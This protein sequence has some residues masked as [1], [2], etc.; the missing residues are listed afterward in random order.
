LSLGGDYMP[1]RTLSRWVGL[2]L[3]LYLALGLDLCVVPAQAQTG[4]S[5][6]GVVTDPSGAVVAGAGVALI[7]AKTQN[8]R[9]TATNEAG[10]YVFPDVDPG[11]YQ[12][13]VTHTGFAIAKVRE[14]VNVGMVSTVNV[15]LLVG[16]ATQE[17]TVEA[18]GVELQTTNATV[19]TTMNFDLA[20]ALPGLSRDVSGLAMLQPA[21]TPVSSSSGVAGSVAGSNADQNKYVLDGGNNSS[22]MDGNNTV[23]LAGFAGNPITGFGSAIP[24]GVVPTPVETIEEFKVGVAGQGGDFNSASGNQVNMVTRRGGDSWHG[25]AYEYYYGTN[26]SANSWENGHTPSKNRSFTPLPSRHENRFGA[27]AGGTILPKLLGGKTYLFGFYQGQ[28]FPNVTT[29]EKPVPSDLMR[30]GVIQIP[31]GSN[32]IPFNLNP[33]PVTVDGVTYAPAT[34][35]GPAGNQPCDP[36]AIGLNPIVSQLWSFMPSGNDVGCGGPFPLANTAILTTAGYTVCDQH[37]TI[38]YKGTI[39]LPV[40][41]NNWVVR[42]DHDFGKNWH[43]MSSYRYYRLI[44]GADT[45][46][47]D[48]GGIVGG[49][50]GQLTALRTYPSYP[51]Y[52]VAGLTTTITTHLTNDFRYNYTY[53]WWKWNGPGARIQPISGLGGAVEIGGED[54]NALIPY[55]VNT[56]QTR[57]RFWDGQDH[58]FRDDLNFLHGNHILQFGGLYQR[59]FNWHDRNDNGQGIS[60]ANVYQVSST[61]GGISWGSYV[62]GTVPQSQISNYQNLAAE[63]LGLVEQPQT[64]YTR[65]GADLHLLP[66]GTHAQD[67]SVIDFYSAYFADTWHFKPTVTLTYGLSYNLEMPPVEQQARQVMLVDQSDN[68]IV[69]GDYFAQRQ[70]AALAGKIYDPVLGFATVGNVGRGRKYPYDPFYGGFG[71]R[72][73]AAWNPRFD[74]GGVL[75]K[76]FGN[77][78][79]VIRGGYSRIYGRLN[80]V[81]LVLVPLLGTGLMQAVSCVGAVAAQFSSGGNQCLGVGGATPATA[82]RIGTDGLVAPL[83]SSPS[84]TLPQPYFPG[85]GGNLAAAPG[86]GLDPQTRPSSNDSFTFSLQREVSSKVFVEAGYIGKLIHNEFQEIN[87]DAVPWMLTLNGQTFANA[88]ANVYTAICG[89]TAQTCPSTNV[90]TPAVQPWFEQ[91]LGG[92]GSVFCAGQ[93][94][95][96]AA[97]IAKERN[98]IGSNSVY[99]L[100]AAMAQSSSWTPGLTNPGMNPPGGCPQVITPTT[101]CKQ[102]TAFEF[103]ASNGWGNYNAAYVSANL[104]DWHGI[105]ARSN[106]TWGRAFG[107]GSEV[108]ARSTRTV[109]NPYDLH[110]SYGTQQFDVKFIYN[111]AM[112]YKLPFYQTQSGILGRVLGGWS[113]A[114]VFTAQSGFPLRVTQTE[115]R[116]TVQAFGQS[117]PSQNS[118]YNA[119]LIN[120]KF[121]GGN[122]L[123]SFNSSPGA[124]GGSPTVNDRGYQQWFN[125]FANPAGAYG[126][127]RRLILGVDTNGG[128]FGILRGFPRWNLDMTFAKD[129]R[130]TERVGITFTALMTNFLNHFQPSDPAVNLNSP[131]TFG[132]VTASEYDARQVEFGL[133]VRF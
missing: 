122:S 62:P 52:F 7:D 26:F 74:G 34:V 60:A 84:N 32:W 99:Q 9:T 57:T 45:S 1:L 47:V 89:L 55:N 16:A 126:Q 59:N 28:R 22:D 39:A 115:S 114:P 33:T 8:A 29:L 123:H 91:A 103:D 43:F 27:S 94:S 129:I 130:T 70:K 132:R 48:M 121:S 97:V 73:S 80:G 85:L 56:Q 112:N 65:N 120:G 5:V 51:A 101:V 31:S 10:R 17:V 118:I 25:S 124:V 66:L 75:T 116:S 119:V 13:I 30:A 67:K 53:N 76:L 90:S 19:G 3:T 100:W 81:N 78:S 46:Q 95:C 14:T 133:R 4:G 128:G 93:P 88:Y 41:D 117:D 24:N 21:T 86:A 64:L 35:C 82:F 63:V 38:G 106:F 36:R 42:L 69:V 15:S 72:V 125:M 54:P 11:N 49:S 20:E 58:L 71:P 50:K 107:T 109:L 37:N 12:L 92:T 110:S 40:R 2:L 104:R 6:S 105:T 18:R 108:Q 68:P 83:G 102:F 127:F 98:F 131:S 113:A 77:N 44:G 87:V 79:T 111:L 61:S 96:T 23:Y